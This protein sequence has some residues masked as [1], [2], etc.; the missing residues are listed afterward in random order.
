M[1]T[2]QDAIDILK[3]TA[4]ELE[5]NDKLNAIYYVLAGKA[6]RNVSIFLEDKRKENG[7]TN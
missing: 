1:E 6:M 4:D 7:K 2:Y 5:K 3:K